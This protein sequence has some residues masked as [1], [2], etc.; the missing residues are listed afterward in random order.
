MKKKCMKLLVW[1]IKPELVYCVILYMYLHEQII[2]IYTF[3]YGIENLRIFSG[4]LPLSI[5]KIGTFIRVY[6]ASS[7]MVLS[8][9]IT[10]TKF[11]FVCVYRAIPTM[12]DN[13]LSL[14]IVLNTN[15][16]IL[17]FT[18]SKFYI[19]DKSL[20]AEVSNFIA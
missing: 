1:V 15:I 14:V 11:V 13:F 19:E 5:C 4:P 10:G 18:M 6:E 12:N 2:F 16:L 8:L 9:I 7:L 3:G 20:M 17:L